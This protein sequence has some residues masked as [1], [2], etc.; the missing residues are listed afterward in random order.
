MPDIENSTVD[1]KS[2]ASASQTV[3]ALLGLRELILGGDLSPGERIS[4]LWVV[5]RLG[6]SRTPVRAGLIRL[7]EEGLVEPIPSGGFA[8]RSFSEYEIRDSIELRGTLEG[9]AA[10]LAAERGISHT[11]F[12]DLNDCV[13]E[14]DALL[15]GEL[16][17]ETFSRYVEANA[18][19]HRLLASASGSQV[20]QR[21]I[22]KASTLPFASASAFVVVQSLD[23]RA[24][25]TLV[26]A[27]AQHRAV[28]SAIEN[29]EGARAE[30]LM[31]EHARIA[32]QNLNRVLENQRALSRLIGGNLIRR[33]TR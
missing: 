4:E 17:E 10:R 2:A 33:G 27:Q 22:E 28:L 3:R 30:A 26:V 25:E 12:R 24:R 32:H 15:V 31:R 5:E 19:F 11:M 1:S 29:R 7:Q 14:I 23:P 20:V 18:N 6:V 21:Q 8:V 16:S 9:L 13:D